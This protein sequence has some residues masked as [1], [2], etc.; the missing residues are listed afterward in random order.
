MI[1]RRTPRHWAEIVA[2]DYLQR[3]GLELVQ[4][5]FATRLGEIDLI[6]RD[7]ETL[8]FIEVRQRYTASH[9]LPEETVHHKKQKKIRLA[10]NQFLQQDH[11]GYDQV[12]R[13]DVFAIEGR[14][15]QA[16]TR[17]IKSAF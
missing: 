15:A 2:H 17:W 5:N 16:Q 13:F 8:V 1:M 10:A 6:M 7:G 14:G 3:H 11:R 12:C 9:G 4:Q